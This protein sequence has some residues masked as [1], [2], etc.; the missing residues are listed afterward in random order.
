MKN[1][2]IFIQTF[3]A[4][5]GLDDVWLQSIMPL[6][7]GDPCR[8]EC[9]L[10]QNGWGHYQ[11]VV[12][13]YWRPCLA[14]RSWVFLIFLWMDVKMG[15]G[16]LPP[17]TRWSPYSPGSH[18]LHWE[19]E[20]ILPSMVLLDLKV[21]PPLHPLCIP[22]LSQCY[23]G[24]GHRPCV[25]SLSSWIDWKRCHMMEEFIMLNKL[26]YRIQRKYKQKTKN[27]YL[28]FNKLYHLIVLFL[29][30]IFLEV[31]ELFFVIDN[32]GT[33]VR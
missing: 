24:W 14:I 23:H 4:L 6:A 9:S 2:I 10:N 29:L 31:K 19:S 3:Q 5:E 11:E 12:M 28:C 7:N 13:H 25:I 26:C 21:G 32:W 20:G 33:A 16:H 17:T 1:E 8:R 27:T 30:P 15:M 18:P 22:N